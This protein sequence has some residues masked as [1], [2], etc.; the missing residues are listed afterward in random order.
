MKVRK[1]NVLENQPVLLDSD[2]SS[3]TTFNGDEVIRIDETSTVNIT[4]F[5]FAPV[6]SNP[7]SAVWKIFILDQSSGVI[8]QYADGNS[9]YDNIWNN[10]TGLSYS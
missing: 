2:T 9:N 5:G 10:R 4:Y 8:K 6:G 3:V 7:A 1:D